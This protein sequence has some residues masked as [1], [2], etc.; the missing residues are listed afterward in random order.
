MRHTPGEQKGTSQQDPKI[1]TMKYMYTLRFA[2]D[3]QIFAQ[4][5]MYRLLI[6]ALF[7]TQRHECI[8]VATREIRSQTRP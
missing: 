8:P 7:P 2:M 4:P 6:Q 1:F 5:G 3:S